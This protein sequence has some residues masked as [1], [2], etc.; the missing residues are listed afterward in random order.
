M[1]KYIVKATYFN[2]I[3]R[4]M[5]TSIIGIYENNEDATRLAIDLYEIYDYVCVFEQEGDENA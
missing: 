1:K 3:E 2:Y 5:E 4:K